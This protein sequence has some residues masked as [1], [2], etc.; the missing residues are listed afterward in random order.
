MEVNLDPARGFFD[1]LSR[2][3]RAPALHK[4]HPEDAQA[5][6]VIHTNASSSRQT[7]CRGYSTY[8]PRTR[9]VSC[10]SCRL[11]S[12]CGLRGGRL[13]L[14]LP[15]TLPQIKD[16]YICTGVD[17]VNSVTRCSAS[18]AVQVVTLHKD[19]VVTKAP[20]PNVTFTFTLQLHSFAYV[21]P[22]SLNS[23]CPVDIGE[24]TQ[25]KAISSRRIHVSIHS[26]NRTA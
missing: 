5:P 17:L 2:V 26:Y 22:C 21:Q 24:L 3:I 20:D 1:A 16:L 14:H 19:G 12:S 18:F 6:E 8:G 4:A 25:A 7:D 23:F 9:D 11:G 10:H 15:V 13:L